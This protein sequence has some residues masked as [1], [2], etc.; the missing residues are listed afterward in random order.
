MRKSVIIAVTVT[1][2]TFVGNGL[3]GVVLEQREALAE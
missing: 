1:S 2:G 3:F